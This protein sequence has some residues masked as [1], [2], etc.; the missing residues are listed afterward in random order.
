MRRVVTGHDASGKSVFVSEGEPPHGV[1]LRGVPRFRIDEVW[2]VV[3][4]PTLPPASGEPTT[5]QHPF[6]PAPGGT[7]FVMV[8]FPPESDV[9]RAAESGTDIPAAQQEFYDSFPG[10]AGTMEPD[11]PGMHTSQ[12]VDYGVVIRGEV[13]LELDDGAKR[14]LKPGD[15]VIQNGTRHAWHNTSDRECVMGFVVVGANKR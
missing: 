4:V 7:G 10:L 3:G 9:T 1:A 8:T 2:S 15:C 6:F 5:Q 12:T 11:A 14:L 13:W